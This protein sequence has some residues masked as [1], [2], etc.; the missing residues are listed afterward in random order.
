MNNSIF[1]K[2]SIDRLKSPEELNDYIRVANPSVWLLLGA[3]ILVLLGVVVWGVFGTVESTL[4][5]GV[6]A[7]EERVICCVSE[8]EV[9]RIQ[10]GMLVRIGDK[11][12]TVGK[13]A[14]TPSEASGQKSYLFHLS[15][16]AA[17]SFYYEV[18]LEV[19]GLE[20][21]IYQG[22]IVLESI[23]PITFVIH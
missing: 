13:V 17:G 6:Q 16:I 9:N 14:D 22:E 18:E 20:A 21:G 1:R 7:E 5:T 3:V 2:S 11:E 10:E 4:Q 23:S 12:G 19:D 15:E 8:T